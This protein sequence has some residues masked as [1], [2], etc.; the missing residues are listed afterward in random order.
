MQLVSSAYAVEEARRNLAAGPQ[1]QRLASL[2]A[3]V[4]TVPQPPPETVPG[5]PELPEKD[6]PIIAAAVAARATHLITGDRKHFGPFFGSR[7]AGV[8]VLPPADY[9][10]DRD[11]AL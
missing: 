3:N 7:A 6:R 5:Y 10:R 9:L 2:L 1:R 8:L 11:P 4:G